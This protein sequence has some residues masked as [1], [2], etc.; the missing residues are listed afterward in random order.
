MKEKLPLG[1]VRFRP[2]IVGKEQHIKCCSRCP[3]YNE[4][5]SDDFCDVWPDPT[6]TKSKFRQFCADMDRRARNIHY[7]DLN[8]LRSKDFRLI[9][10]PGSIESYYKS[11]LQWAF[12][13]YH[14]ANI[15]IKPKIVAVGVHITS[16]RV[17]S[18]ETI[19]YSWVDLENE[20]IITKEENINNK[21]YIIKEP[22]GPIFLELIQLRNRE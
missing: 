17:I 18:P 5:Q 13:K 21:D 20:K 8:D 16:I 19:S 14:G 6:G 1:I 7:L 9:P 2:L 10:F 12:N 22:L 11:L 4:N 15:L 3:Y